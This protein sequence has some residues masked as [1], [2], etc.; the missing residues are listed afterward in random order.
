MKLNQNVENEMGLGNWKIA[1]RAIVNC[2]SLGQKIEY[3]NYGSSGNFSK[4]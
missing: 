4:P 3:L 2:K 1:R